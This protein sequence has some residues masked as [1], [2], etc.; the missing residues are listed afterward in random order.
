MISRINLLNAKNLSLL[1]K[2]SNL[3]TNLNIIVTL[4]QLIN[5]YC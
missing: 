5:K 4:K 2:P 1:K 3:F